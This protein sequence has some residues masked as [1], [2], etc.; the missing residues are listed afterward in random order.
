M[1]NN[2]N[3]DL[4]CSVCAEMYT[5]PVTLDCGHNFCKA[6][7]LGLWGEPRATVSCPQCGQQ[8]PRRDLVTNQLLV[9]IVA[10]LRHLNLEAGGA[11][12]TG[13]MCPAHCELA[14]LFCRKDLKLV[15]PA[16]LGQEGSLTL[17]PVEEA[18]SFCKGKLEN[19]IGLLEKK[20]EEYRR[21]QTTRG[22]KISETLE[23]VESL[24]GN[25]E[26]EFAKLHQFLQE[27]ETTLSEKLRRESEDLV[28]SLE[29]NFKLISKK[30]S[31]IEKLIAETHSLIQTKD[32]RRLLMDTKSVLQRSDLHNEPILQPPDLSVGDFN[33]PLQYA[34]WKQMLSIISPAPD[35][36][37]FD[38]ET[39]NPSLILSKDHTMVKRRTKFKQ[40]PENPKRFTFCVAVLAT[41]GFTG[42]QH[43]WEVDVENMSGW[44]VG[45]AAETVNR[46]DDVALTPANGFWSMRLWNGKVHWSHGSAD[47]KPERVGVYLDYERGQLSFYNSGDMSHL[48]T[49]YHRFVEKLY[50]FILPLPNLETAETE[51]LKLFHLYL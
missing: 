20:L 33:G 21:A 50:P 16:C 41:E 14:G 12:V 8:L 37:I 27:Q 39:A 30:S 46:S 10:S 4:S 28:Q 9:T 29:G 22:S 6:C 38:P 42:G 36:L 18:Y 31:S 35:P 3:R 44:I 34:A 19:S 15:C 40:L 11:G 47:T 17:I 1:A 45:V 51:L 26:A 32:Q 5:E 23:L 24:Q 48:Y 13:L 49:F 2:L 25:I 43:Y 7:V